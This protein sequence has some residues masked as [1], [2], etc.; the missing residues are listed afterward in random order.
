VTVRPERDHRYYRS[1]IRGLYQPPADFPGRLALSDLRHL[2][3]I[4]MDGVGG[5]MLLVDAALHRGG[6]VFPEKPY[7]DL[8][9]TEGFGVLAKD[10]GIAPVG[11]PRVEI[12]HVPW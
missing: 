6:L 10:L 3:R 1:T 7:R 5:T 8:V 11:L 4:E 2:E 12:F 9:E